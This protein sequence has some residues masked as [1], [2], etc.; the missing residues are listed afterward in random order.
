MLAHVCFSTNH[1]SAGYVVNTS[2][3]H[4]LSILF[5]VLNLDWV[6]MGAEDNLL[7]FVSAPPRRETESMS[8]SPAGKPLCY[9]GVP[10]VTEGKH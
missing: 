10:P 4:F 3:L 2:H 6:D 7:L 9:C 1:H 5:L 8:T